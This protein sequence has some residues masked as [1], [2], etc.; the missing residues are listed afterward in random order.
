MEKKWIGIV[1]IAILIGAVA[2][3]TFSSSEAQYGLTDEGTGLEKGDTPPQ[4]KLETL[5]GEPLSLEDVKG[6]KVIVNFWATWCEPCREEM[7]V[8]EEYDAQNEDVVVV[9]VNMT[10]KDG[11]IEKITEFVNEY[12]LTFPVLLDKVGDVS[13]AYEVINI[14]S[15]YF[16]DEEGIIQLKIN[17]ALDETMLDLYM[18]QL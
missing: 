17:G 14:P 3:N 16:L 12:G 9:A 15:T 8:F 10:H 5:D 18:E 4:F 7:P 13:K 11:K 2:W 1:I 6:K